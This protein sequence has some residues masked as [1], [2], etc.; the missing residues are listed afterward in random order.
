MERIRQGFAEVFA[1]KTNFV[2]DEFYV[3]QSSQFIN[4][5][6]GF[7]GNGPA[8]IEVKGKDG[9][10]RTYPELTFTESA[11]KIVEMRPGIIRFR[12]AATAASTMEVSA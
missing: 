1:N 7:T 6:I 8:Y 3:P 5:W 9:T 12:F 2:S 11:A 10:W 4:L